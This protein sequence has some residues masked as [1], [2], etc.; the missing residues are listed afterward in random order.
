[1]ISDSGVHLFL[2]NRATGGGHERQT[3]LRFGATVQPVGEILEQLFRL[4]QGQRVHGGLV[5]T[6]KYAVGEIA[7]STVLA[8]T[9]GQCQL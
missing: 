8:P 3:V 5:G 1:M 7:S 2:R 4:R 9:I 6:L